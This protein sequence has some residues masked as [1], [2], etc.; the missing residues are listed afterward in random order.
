MPVFWVANLTWMFCPGSPCC[1]RTE[2]AGLI[3]FCTAAPEDWASTVICGAQNA[4][5]GWV[6]DPMDAQF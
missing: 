1:G 4:V 3:D 5:A 2:V 6:S